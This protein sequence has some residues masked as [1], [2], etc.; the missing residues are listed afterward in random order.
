MKKPTQTS[1]SSAASALSDSDG[2]S[3]HTLQHLRDPLLMH[4]CR[5]FDHPK[6]VRSI[7]DRK[8]ALI[9]CPRIVVIE[10]MLDGI[11]IW[12]NA[13]LG[14]LPK[15]DFEIVHDPRTLNHTWLESGRKLLISGSWWG[16]LDS[17]NDLVQRLFARN[18]QLEHVIYLEPHYQGR[19][20]CAIDREDLA[21]T[22]AKI[23]E[24]A[25]SN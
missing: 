23:K 16:R 1:A 14:C 17:V 24:W 5:A 12:R 19:S 21:K 13:L 8:P 2:H 15:S 22:I 11:D 20:G 3:G 18:G 10:T 6:D 9:L 25:S 7:S 4:A